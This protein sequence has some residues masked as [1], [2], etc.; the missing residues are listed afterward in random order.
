MEALKES[1]AYDAQEEQ[2]RGVAAITWNDAS[3]F[4]CLPEDTLLGAALRAGVG[5]PY[6]CNAG[7]CGSCKV[8]LLEGQ[9]R[10][11]RPDAPGIKPRERE[12]GKVLACQ[13]VPEGDCKIAFNED[14]EC[15]P[16]IKPRRRA[17]TLA[18]YRAI[19]RD[20]R[21]FRFIADHPAEF[22]PGQYA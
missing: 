19:T 2:R 4:S 10:D 20:I 8:V 13:C 3:S 1:A 18:S 9:V 16:V 22:L 5:L 21:E 17:V 15:R 6:E 11:L 7:G 14:V 12:R